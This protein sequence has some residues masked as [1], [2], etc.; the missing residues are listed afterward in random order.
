MMPNLGQLGQKRIGKTSEGRSIFLNPDGSMSSE[1]STTVMHPLINGGKPTNI[2]TIFNGRE[3]SEDEA[4]EIIAKFSQ[5][6]NS[7]R[8]IDPETGR[9]LGTF[10][11]IPLA[12]IAAA[13]RSR[14]LTRIIDPQFSMLLGQQ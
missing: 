11:S 9:V 13:K 4:A 12:E 5:G 1:R 2:P 6:Q 7:I 3:F 14:G 8:P 10:Q